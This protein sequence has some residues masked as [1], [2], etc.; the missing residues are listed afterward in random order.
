[1]IKFIQASCLETDKIDSRQAKAVLKH[2]PDIILFEYPQ[3]N[4]TPETIF[5]KYSPDKKPKKEVEKII[6]MLKKAGKKYPW[7]LSDIKVFENIQKLWSERKQVYLYFI[8]A[9]R[10]ITSY[11]LDEHGKS[12]KPFPK[13]KKYEW[14]W[15]QMSER[16]EYMK[17]HLKWVL[18]K[19]KN[20][21]LK[22]LVFLEKF[23]WL[24]VKSSL[25]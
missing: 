25:L 9:P 10:K 3:E 6:K 5:N 7:I 20:K 4:K 11:R 16:E 12:P 23:H 8:D 18:K 15:K 24:H 22:I 21:D 2:K 17:R 14:W 19:H 13:I 1:M